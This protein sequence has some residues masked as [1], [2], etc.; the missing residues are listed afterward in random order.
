[1]GKIKILQ[2]VGSLGIGGNEMFVMNFFR[3]LDKTKYQVDFL[4]FENRLD[5]YDEVKEAGSKV[6][7]CP[8]IK[9]NKLKQLIHQMRYVNKILKNNKYD[10]LHCHG[11]S[12]VNIMRSSIPGWKKKNIKV[13]T[14]S[15]NTGMPKNTKIDDI[16]RFF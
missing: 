4:I 8:E 9:G 2:S 7:I 11:C 15:H 13:I 14:H 10:V 1:M 16:L 12:F 6:F 3:H 5:F